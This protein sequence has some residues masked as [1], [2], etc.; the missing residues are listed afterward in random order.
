MHEHVS[1]QERGK[2]IKYAQLYSYSNILGELCTTTFNLKKPSSNNKILDTVID[3]AT[4]S[5]FGI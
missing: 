3:T 4:Y 1:M 5:Y 2:Y